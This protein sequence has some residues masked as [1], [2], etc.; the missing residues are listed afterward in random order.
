[1]QNH[2]YNTACKLSIIFEHASTGFAEIDGQGKIISINHTGEILLMPLRTAQNFSDE[3]LFPLLEYIA[4][5]LVTSINSFRDQTGTISTNAQHNFTYVLD[6]EKVKKHF[7]FSLHKMFTDCIIISFADIT[8]K[9]EQELIIREL[10]SDKAVADGKYEIASNILHDIG[11]AVVGFGSY[12][13]RIKRSLEQANPDKLQKMTEFFTAQQP[14]LTTAFGTDKAGAVIKMMTGITESQRN[15][16]EEIQKSVEDQLN[17]ITHIQEILHIQRQYTNGHNSSERLPVNFRSIIN[18]C[19]SMLFAALEKRH[20]CVSVHVPD[21]LPAFNAD[22]TGL[23][24]VILNLLKNSMEAIDINAAEK[25]IS[26]NVSASPASFILQ[27]GDNG[28]G[29]DRLHGDRLFERGFSTKASGSGIGLSSCRS[30]LESHN[31]TIDIISE[32]Q[33]KGSLATIKF[34]L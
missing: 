19:M 8:L 6:G 17:I 23:M 1:M 22:R 27:I 11:N 33:G 12:I 28:H 31:G 2:P 32:G 4:P 18:D 21:S 7:V 10:L 25:K 29:F 14:A 13:T 24:Q 15:N 26:I 9:C 34:K 16:A 20:I 30:I 3:N 5:E